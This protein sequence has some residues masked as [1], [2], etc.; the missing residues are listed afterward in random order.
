MQ[1][2]IL[3]ATASSLLSLTLNLSTHHNLLPSLLNSLALG[4]SIYLFQI[5]LKQV[6][7]VFNIFLVISLGLIPLFHYSPDNQFAS[8][9]PLFSLG[10]LF[11]YVIIQKGYVLIIFGLFLLIGNIY[12]SGI[13][14][15]PFNVQYS[16][17][18]FNSPE[19]NYNINRHQQ[20]AL[21]IPYQA[22]LI[23]YSKLIYMYALLTNS[24]NLLNLK[25]FA[26][27]LLIANLYP[28]FKGLYQV[29]TNKNTSWNLCMTA[30]LITFLTIGVDRSAEKFKSLYLLGPIFI[31]LIFLGTKKLNKKLYLILWII[32][33]LI[34]ISPKI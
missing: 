29:F 19:I 31:Y 16:Q 26:D 23:V 8:F 22:R 30:F 21:F 10:L 27:I 9:L 14:K 17:I 1:S 34:F 4:L 15:H 3:L 28:L 7:S 13:I 2:P 24:F 20:D 5:Y 33:F 6:K 32:S 12:S 11:L 25:N 18:I